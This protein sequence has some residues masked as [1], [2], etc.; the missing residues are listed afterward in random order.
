MIHATALVLHK[1][2]MLCSIDMYLMKHTIIQH[3]LFMQILTATKVQREPA[4]CADVG[5]A[6]G[7]FGEVW[8]RSKV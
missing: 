4:I 6:Q 8:T 3:S 7:D 1:L 2:V 5:I